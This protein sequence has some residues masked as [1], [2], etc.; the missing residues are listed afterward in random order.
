MANHSLPKI[1]ALFQTAGSAIDPGAGRA[2]FITA[3]INGTDA[4][5][6]AGVALSSSDD[7]ILGK[8]TNISFDPPLQCATAETVT[9]ATGVTIAYFIGRGTR[10]TG[11]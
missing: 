1:G 9:P 11:N 6:A 8:N 5:I 2:V 10:T 3:I 7:I 4:V